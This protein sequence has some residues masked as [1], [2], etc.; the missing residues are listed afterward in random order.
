MYLGI[1]WNLKVKTM[2]QQL[3]NLRILIVKS[4]KQISTKK[5]VRGWIK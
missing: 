5:G 2:P 4:Y 3:N 1:M